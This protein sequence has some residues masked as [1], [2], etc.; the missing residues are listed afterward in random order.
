MPRTFCSDPLNGRPGCGD[1]SRNS[2]TSNAIRLLLCPPSRYQGGPHQE[3]PNRGD[4]ILAAFPPGKYETS[5]SI[6]ESNGENMNH[7]VAP[8]L[9][10]HRRRTMHKKLPVIIQGGMG[11]AVSNWRL[12]NAVSSKG[13]LGVVSGVALGAILARRLEMGD[14]GGH[15]RRALAAFPVREAAKGILEKYFI[16]GGKDPDER[17]AVKPMAKMN[18]SRKVQDLIVAGNFVEVYLAKEGHD[19]PVGVNFLEKI[20]VTTLPSLYGAM[21]AGVDY[22]LMGAGIPRYIPGVLDRLA[23][24]FDVDLKVDVKGLTDEG[25]P[26][27]RFSPADFAKDIVGKLKR[28]DFLAIVSSHILARM[29]ATK[30]NGEVNGFVVELPVAGGHN[31]P[32]RKKGEFTDDGEPIY[33]ERD[34]PDLQIIAD[35]G[36]PFWLA[37][38]YGEPGMVVEALKS[39]A[40]G[41]QVGTAFAYCD[42]SGFTREIKDEVIEKSRSGTLKVFTDAVASPTGFPFKVIEL[43]D[44]LSNERVYEK[45][46]RICDLGYL[47]HAYQR[48]DATIGWRCPSEP[49]DDYVRKGGDIA[50][51]VGRKCLCNSLVANVGLPQI[52][53]SGEIEGILITSGDDAANVSRFAP[54]GSTSYS[55]ADVL[56]YLLSEVENQGSGD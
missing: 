7:A 37:G 50:D 27:I 46:T 47:R 35:L 52:Q 28:P 5:G 22:I 36:K 29:L 4:I 33:G 20:Q 1:D 26:Y 17:F 48:E 55:A 40:S 2:T 51:T 30:S 32:P 49:V 53:R 45:R 24:G 15:M 39:G 38:G 54:E 6:R 42:E 31:A 21:L 56:T 41:V 34:V 11:V 43:D 44:T 16:A 3:Y 14:P 12:A 19:N 9:R 8:T 23:E 25:D 18:T 10:P 13:Q